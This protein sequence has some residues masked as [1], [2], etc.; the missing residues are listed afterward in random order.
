MSNHEQ[1]HPMSLHFESRDIPK[2]LA[3]YRDV[4]GFELQSVWPGEG[5]PLWCSLHLNGQSIMLG[6]PMESCQSCG[7]PLTDAALGQMYCQYCVDESGK[8][9]PYEA[10]LEGTISGYF[11]GMQK[12]ERGAAEVAAKEHLSRLPAWTCLET[13]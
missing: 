4:L 9:R 2:A 10:I 3:F 6:G 1:C 13:K 12:M 5:E 8:L 11:M 7:M